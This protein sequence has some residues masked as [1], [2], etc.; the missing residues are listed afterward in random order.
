MWLA[1]THGGS[2]LQCRRRS[3]HKNKSAQ[4]GARHEDGQHCA[5]SER[6]QHFD[7]QRI[8][9][10]YTSHAVSMMV[11]MFEK[12]EKR[13]SGESGTYRHDSALFVA[14]VPSSQVTVPARTP[15]ALLKVALLLTIGT[16]NLR[17]PHPRVPCV[18]RRG[19]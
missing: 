17:F 10:A 11:K 9:A 6:Q 18:P 1:P 3:R 19:H 13:M 5:V 12:D 14:Y 2:L 8:Q 4:A 15:A 7:A 16:K